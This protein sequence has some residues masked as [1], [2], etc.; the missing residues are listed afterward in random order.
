MIC[1][2]DNIINRNISS[3]LAG[4]AA[5]FIILGIRELV[6]VFRSY[7]ELLIVIMAICAIRA[8]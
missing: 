3:G 2:V 4:F 7:L 8:L 5:V 1:Y 6:P